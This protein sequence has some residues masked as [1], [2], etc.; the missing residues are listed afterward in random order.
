MTF[1]SP[2]RESHVVHRC[3]M[4]SSNVLN[5]S[6]FFADWASRWNDS[7]EIFN[8]KKQTFLWVAE[9]SSYKTITLSLAK[10]W[11]QIDSISKTIFQMI[12]DTSMEDLKKISKGEPLGFQTTLPVNWGNCDF[13][14]KLQVTFFCNLKGSSRNVDLGI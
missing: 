7:I 10:K 1:V 14:T 2:Y 12:K 8:R 13:Y 3:I 5:G 11:F 4:L 6:A 9:A